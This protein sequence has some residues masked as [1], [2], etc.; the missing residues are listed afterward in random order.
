MSETEK[1]AGDSSAPIESQGFVGTSQEEGLDPGSRAVADALRLTFTVLK[2]VMICIV[3][4]FLWSGFYT[5]EENEVAIKLR[6][7]K[8]QGSGKDRVKLPGLHWKWPNPIDEVIKVPAS[9]AERILKIDSFWYYEKPGR[10]KIAQY[11]SPSIPLRFVQ[12]GYTLTA[13]S[14]TKQIVPDPNDFLTESRFARVRAPGADY[15][16]AHSRWRL[17]Y[18]ISDPLG[19]VE[20]LWDGT[21]GTSS[22]Q[23]GWYAVENLLRNAVSDAV[24]LVSAHRDIDEIIWES[25]LQYSM[26][27]RR[28]AEQ[29]LRVLEVGI[30]ITDLELLDRSPPLQVKRDFDAAAMAGINAQKLVHQAQAERNEIVNKSEG[31]AA[32]IKAEAE[33]YSKIVEKAAEA[34]AAYLSEVLSKIKTS[35]QEKSKG[36]AN[37]QSAYDKAYA[38]LLAVTVDQLYQETLRDVIDNADEVF[39]IPSTKEEPT[40]VRMHFSRDATLRPRTVED[41]N[42]ESN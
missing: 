10:Q 32:V 38:E 13:S 17:R 1:Q 34:E 15:N 3:A 25:P 22:K 11:S 39:V 26:D 33:G 19:F 20:Y 2:L 7:G 18:H 27:V 21:E 12:D 23:D 41:E 24:I 35:A 31:D 8:V 42:K 9:K 4:V 16:I 36:S 6:F 5:V 30:S 29:R 14:G 40:E 37:L 28:R